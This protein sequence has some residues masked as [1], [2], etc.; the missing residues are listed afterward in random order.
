MFAWKNE[1]YFKTIEMFELFLKKDRLNVNT[2]SLTTSSISNYFHMLLVAKL[3][4]HWPVN[5]EVLGLNLGGGATA[6][7]RLYLF[8][9]ALLSSHV[10]RIGTLTGRSRVS[11]SILWA[12]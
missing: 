3:I 7:Y 8:G 11:E 6:V 5:P 12:R 4:A 10:R 1:N 9:K 2:V